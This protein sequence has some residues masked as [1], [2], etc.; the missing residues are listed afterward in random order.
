VGLAVSIIVTSYSW[1]TIYIYLIIYQVLTIVVSLLIFKGRTGHKRYPLYQID[2][3]GSALFITAG[4]TMAYTMI[5]GPKYYWFDDSRIVFSAVASLIALG[6]FMLRLSAAKRPMVN[7][8]VFKHRNFIIGLILLAFYYGVKDSINLIY[9]YTAS[10]LKWGTTDTVFLALVS[11]MGM[12]T[13]MAITAQLLL[14]YRHHITYFFVTGFSLMLFYHLYIFYIITPDLAFSDL[15]IPVFIQ[16]AAS[17]T[18]MVPIVI[19]ILSSVPT[20]TGTTGVVVAAYTRFT[21]TLNSIAGFYSLQ[22][23]YNQSHREGLLNGLSIED[24]AMI[25]R[26]SDYGQSAS[27]AY[28]SLNKV[29]VVQAQL[30]TIRSVFIWSSAA[31]VLTLVLILL[32]PSLN[33]TMLHW[34]KRM[35]IMRRK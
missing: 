9:G 26:L 31:L 34:N 22:L 18:L 29:V 23:Y 24:T 12:I 14:R 33:K 10:V 11:V 15:V 1:K 8:D 30:L 6:A 19:F 16:G 5:Y 35:F 21:A 17:G 2:W 27:T 3:L 20:Y 32:I 28:S 4:I 25:Q 7:L 13:A